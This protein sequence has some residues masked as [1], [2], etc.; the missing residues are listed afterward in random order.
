MVGGLIPDRLLAL[1]REHAC[2]IA[3]IKQA[4]L[5]AA[6]DHAHAAVVRCCVIKHDHDRNE[7]SIGVREE[8]KVLVPVE[9]TFARGCG[10]GGQFRVLQ[11]DI[12]TYQPTEPSDDALILRQLQE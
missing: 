6:P 2:L 9:T 8:G 12:F 10:L 4:S 11:L 7:I 5:V 3:V 1:A